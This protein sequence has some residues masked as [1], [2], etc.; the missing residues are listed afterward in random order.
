MQTVGTTPEHSASALAARPHPCSAAMP[1][2]M[3]APEEANWP[4][5]GSPFVRAVSAA[6]A[7]TWEAAAESAPLWCDPSISSHTTD[8]P[9]GS[10][11]MSAV[12]APG[13]WCWSSR[14]TRPKVVPVSLT[15][16]TL[17]GSNATLALGALRAGG[18]EHPGLLVAVGAH[19]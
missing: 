14:T 12:A 6:V 5:S 4:I 2:R 15:D 13:T 8:R 9:P 11:L 17:G 16:T 7:M 18:D 1:S 10:S 3:S 19:D